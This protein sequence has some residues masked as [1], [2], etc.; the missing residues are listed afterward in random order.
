MFNYIEFEDLNLI[1]RTVVI[2]NI[3]DN[4][5]FE[6]IFSNTGVK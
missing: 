3:Y 4:T 1:E 5:G 6:I 2:F